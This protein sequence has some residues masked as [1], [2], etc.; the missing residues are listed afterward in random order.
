MKATVRA[1]DPVARR[2]ETD[3]GQL[4]CDVLV[5]APGWGGVGLGA[6][7]GGVGVGNAVR[8]YLDGKVATIAVLKCLGARTAQIACKPSTP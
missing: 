2:V 4:D 8:A 5:V 7:V 6:Q 1:I 3:A